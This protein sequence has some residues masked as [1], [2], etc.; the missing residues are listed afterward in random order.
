MSQAKDQTKTTATDRA[1]TVAAAAAMCLGVGA[2]LELAQ[3]QLEQP[4]QPSQNKTN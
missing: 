3:A 2:C 4:S 1:I